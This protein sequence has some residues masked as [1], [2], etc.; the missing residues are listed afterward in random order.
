MR[1]PGEMCNLLEKSKEK[2]VYLVQFKPT[3]KDWV[4]AVLVQS[5]CSILCNCIVGRSNLN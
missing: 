1:F 2:V 5:F 3:D 4:C